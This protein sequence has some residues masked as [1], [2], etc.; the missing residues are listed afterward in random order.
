MA[1]WA[2]QSEILRLLWSWWTAIVVLIKPRAQIR[3]M[4]LQ[5]RAWRC[6]T[7]QSPTLLFV[8]RI[9]WKNRDRI[10]WLI[11]RR[12]SNC[13]ATAVARCGHKIGNSHFHLPRRSSTAALVCYLQIFNFWFYF[14][15]LYFWDFWGLAIFDFLIIF[16]Y[17]PLLLRRP[18]RSRIGVPLYE[19]FYT[20]P[21]KSLISTIK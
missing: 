1:I 4:T 11:Q 18:W 14:W 20:V 17:F 2:I 3:L 7:H 10:K 5:T 9:W 12:N 16:I 21:K 8:H 15:G 6:L 19:P 13:P